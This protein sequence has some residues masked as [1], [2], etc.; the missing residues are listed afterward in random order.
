VGDGACCSS[1][2]G[3]D[4]T[5]LV[6]DVFAEEQSKLLPLP[7]E[8]FPAHERVEVEIGKTPYAGF[9]LNDYSVPHDRGHRSLT[10]WPISRRF[11]FSMAPMSLL[12]TVGPGIATSR[13]SKVSIHRAEV[14]DIEADTYRLKEAKE[15]N[16]ARVKRRG[17]KSAA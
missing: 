10:L 5:R 6:R 17:K 16:A 3:E 13:S 14:I 4:R 2:L 1:S 12:C 8:Q 11:A 9:D 7:D 15:F